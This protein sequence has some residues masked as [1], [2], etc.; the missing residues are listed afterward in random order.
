MPRAAKKDT[1]LRNDPIVLGMAGAYLVG[2]LMTGMIGVMT[3]GADLRSN[4]DYN[5]SKAAFVENGLS[6]KVDASRPGTGAVVPADSRNVI[7][8]PS[9]LSVFSKSFLKDFKAS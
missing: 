6:S 8:D 3:S 2:M 5:Q 9:S 4:I 1:S 7:L